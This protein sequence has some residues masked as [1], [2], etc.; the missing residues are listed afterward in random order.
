MNPFLEPLSW[1][2][3]REAQA[4]AVIDVELAR[5]ERDL[6][7]SERFWSRIGGVSEL[8]QGRRPHKNKKGLNV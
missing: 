4:R 7:R 8:Q 5:E 1:S 3:L 2:W 6:E